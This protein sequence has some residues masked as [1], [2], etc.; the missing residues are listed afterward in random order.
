MKKG[1]TLFDLHELGPTTLGRFIKRENRFLALAKVEGRIAKIH[2]ADTGRLEEI[3]TPGRPL[4][5]LANRPGMKTD[6]TLLAARMQEGWVLV[7]T[8]FHRPIAA[9]A[10]EKGVLGFIPRHLKEEVIFGKSRFDYL[11]DDMYVELKGCSLVQEGLCLFPNAP[12]TRGV[13]HLKALIHAEVQGYRAA[14]LIMALRPCRCFSPHPTRDETFRRTF[15]EA[16]ERG[17]RFYG[18]HI[19][20]LE[21]AIVYDGPLELCPRS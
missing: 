8:R 15:Y 5:L 17:V 10:I 4:R 14:I 9:A 3:L 2:I 1:E 18:F 12:T 6:Y 19:R 21:N 7:N 20:M 11:A 16:L 13:K